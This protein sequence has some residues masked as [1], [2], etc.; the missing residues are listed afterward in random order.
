[1]EPVGALEIQDIRPGR[2][3]GLLYKMKDG[4]TAVIVW[5]NDELGR[6]AFGETGYEVVGAED[7]FGSTVATE[8][9][10]YAVGKM[11]VRFVLKPSAEAPMEAM[12]RLRVSDAEGAPVWPQQT[13]A[14]FVPAAGGRFAYQPTGG[15]TTVFEGRTAWGEPVKRTGLRFAAGGSETFEVSVPA[16]AGL[17]LK[18]SFLLDETG[19][20]AEVLVDGKPAGNWNLLRTSPDLA[21][22]LR[23]SVFPVAAT[24]LGGKPKVSVELRYPKGGT[25]AGWTV[26]EYRGGAFPLTA[27]GAIHA[28]QN[29]GAPRPG[30]N[31]VSGPLKVGEERFGNGLGCFAMS[32]QEFSLGGRFKRFTA[33]VGVDAVTEGR[34]SVIFEVYGDGKKLWASPVMS[35]LDP[36][37]AVDVSVEGVDRLRLVVGDGGDG[38]RYD[39][40]DWC[41]PVLLP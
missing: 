36:A 18:K 39:V 28:D 10:A 17:V 8:Q 20:T 29:V 13:L 4:R 21:A 16:G 26:F 2:S 37:R 3:A 12:S 25:T 11:P 23:E 1:M 9:G 15:T 38:N 22:G 24:A 40:A 14:A 5:R 33:K 27:M 34:G 19:H 6:V 7:V 31:T 35:G 32:L 41:D 30:R